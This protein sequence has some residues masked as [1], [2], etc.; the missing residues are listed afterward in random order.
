MPKPVDIT[1]KLTSW[2]TPQRQSTT[3]SAG[4][5]VLRGGR[6]NIDLFSALVLLLVTVAV[7]SQFVLLAAM[8]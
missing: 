6:R 3:P 1:D 4:Q 2:N 5:S 7:L 8:G